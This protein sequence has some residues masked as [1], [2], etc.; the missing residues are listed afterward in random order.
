MSGP[1]FLMQN[2]QLE[3]LGE[4]NLLIF[5]ENWLVLSIGF[6]HPYQSVHGPVRRMY[7]L[8]LTDASR[9]RERLSGTLVGKR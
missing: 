3:A 5:N 7:G 8:W 4:D 1:A 9:Y 6:F 2:H